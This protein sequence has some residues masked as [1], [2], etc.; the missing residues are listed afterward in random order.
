MIDM[1]NYYTR[2]HSWTN[3]ATISSSSFLTHLGRDREGQI[4]CMPERTSANT[5]AKVQ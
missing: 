5:T 3:V 2:G 4:D 1:S